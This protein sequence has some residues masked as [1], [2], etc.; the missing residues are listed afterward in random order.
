MTD[1]IALSVILPAYDLE[2]VLKNTLQ[3]AVHH[4]DNQR[5]VEPYELVA[6]NDGSRDGTATILEKAKKEISNLSVITHPENSGYGAAMLSGIRHARY[7][8]LLLMDADGQ[9]K[10]SSIDDFIPDLPDY[11]ISTGYRKK[12]RDPLHRVIIGKAYTLLSAGLFGLRY[13]DVNCGFK[14]CK[15]EVFD[16]LDITSHAGIFYTEVFI[17]AEEKGCRITE[18]SI[19]H[20]PRSTGKQTGA[21]T[22]VILK[23]LNDLIRL[24]MEK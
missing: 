10:L 3:E 7:P 8:L 24:K 2:S 15:K 1:K 6:V 4:L 18:R 16:S 19:K 20:Y 21:S 13:Q 14:L 17:K 22:R 5:L 11:D 12:R 23:A 9:F